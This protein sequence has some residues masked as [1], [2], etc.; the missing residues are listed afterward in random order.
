MV[1]A[2]CAGILTATAASAATPRLVANPDEGPGGTIVALTGTGFCVSCGVV[3]IDFAAT[4]VK[5]G[6]VVG[7]DGS[8]STT[9][10]VPGGAQAG[11]DM[12][13]AFQQSVLVAQVAFNVTPSAP[14]PTGQP[15]PVPTHSN[16]AS[17]SPTPRSTPTA[18]PGASQVPSSPPAPASATPAAASRQDLT[19]GLAVALV[20]V[21]AAAAAAIGLVAWRRR[22]V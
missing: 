16:P 12:I 10:M 5:R 2:C 9:I 20:L 7:S 8:F 4:P 17:P 18:T 14:P 21:I 3:E 22:R 6:L 15:S 11:T 19:A 1:A 13:N